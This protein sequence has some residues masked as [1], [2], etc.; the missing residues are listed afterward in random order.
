MR[1]EEG[2]IDVE[3]FR[4]AA[5]VD[6]VS[7]TGATWLG[8]T[9][10]CA[11]CHTHKFDPITQKEYYQFLSYF[12]N[13]D[14]PEE[15][16]IPDPAIA[17]K[18][19]EILAE[20]DRRERS[21][22]DFFPAEDPEAGWVVAKPVD[23]KSASGATL[24]SGADGLVT[25]GGVSPDQDVYTIAIDRPESLAAIR[26]DALADPSSPAFGPGRTPHGNFVLTGVSIA[27]VPDGK[28]AIPVAIGSASAD[29]TQG[30]FNPA[31]L[32]DD[33]KRTGWAIDDGSGRCDKP[34][35]ATLAIKDWPKVEGPSK[36]ILTLKQE[37]GG[38]HTLGRFRVRLKSNEV[39]SDPRPLEQSRSEFISAKRSA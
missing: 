36:V 23:S 13:A 6:R 26:I 34:R 39:A 15:Y 27:V 7:T 3:E 9:I 10:Q 1:N 35:T 21:L 18:R 8:L 24:T 17:A 22:A 38:Q 37:Y 4:Y 30:T 11:Q 14:E 12:N 19:A 31:G 32:L 29:F 20:A 5:L 28:A 33:D 16:D 2:G 25:A